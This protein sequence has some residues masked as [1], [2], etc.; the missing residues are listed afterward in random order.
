MKK[1]LL[2]TFIV[3]LVP[4][5]SFAQVDDMYY[6][7]SKADKEARK[8]AAE[9]KAAREAA[10]AAQ[11]RTY[12]PPA[13]KPLEMSVD[14][15][16]RRHLSS[17]YEKIGTDSVGNDIIEFSAGDG[18]YPARVDTVYVYK[19][20]DSDDFRYSSRLG[21]FDDF[22]GWYSPFLYGWRGSY[23]NSFYYPYYGSWYLNRWYDPW[24]LGWYGWYDW[25]DPWYYGYYRWGW[26]PWYYSYYGWGYPWYSGYGYRYGWYG[27]YTGWY[28]GGGGIAYGGTT[29]TRNHGNVAHH[30]AMSAGITRHDG[31]TTTSRGTFGG[32]TVANGTYGASSGY[33][34]TDTRSHSSSS[35]RA[36]FGGSRATSSSGSYSGSS[37]PSRVSTPS[38]SNVGSG[39]YGGGSRSSGG[40]FGGGGS[41]S[42]GGFSG[43]GHFGG[44]G[45]GGSRGRR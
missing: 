12:T 38:S 9:A 14:E 5:S 18:T 4:L 19:Y 1:F 41:R 26:D 30:S 10:A 22:Y 25:Y 17:S 16:N 3:G 33:S 24:Y 35:P 39:S 31:Y 44:G 21:L 8:A 40:S 13:P 32:R 20:D 27:W 15:Y 36:G 42:G 6:V 34:G 45:G 23:W 11:A 7:P 37:T 29:G 43:G 2:I 28:G